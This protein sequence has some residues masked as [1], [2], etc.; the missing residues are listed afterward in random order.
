MFPKSGTACCFVCSHPNVGQL[1]CASLDHLLLCNSYCSDM[2]GFFCSQLNVNLEFCIL[3][4]CVAASYVS[5]QYDDPI[6]KGQTIQEGFFV[7]IS[8]LQSESS[9]PSLRGLGDTQRHAR[10]LISGPSLG[11]KAKFLSFNRTQSRAVT[12]LTGHNTLRRHLHLL[13]LLGGPLCRRRGVKAETSAHILCECEALV[14]LR[15]TYLGCFFLEP[16]DIKSINLGAI[17]NFS[18]VTG[19]P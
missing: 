6:F 5:R 15:R 17:W 10:E 19:L 3:L 9:T 4:G 13:G 18:K 11:A 12:G 7:G 1:F 2:Q 8:F 14:S 16:W